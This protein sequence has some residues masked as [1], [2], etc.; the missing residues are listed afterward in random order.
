MRM[1]QEGLKEKRENERQMEI[2]VCRK[3]KEEQ[4]RKDKLEKM[5]K[6]EGERLVFFIFVMIRHQFGVL[7][8]SFFVGIFCS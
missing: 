4:K 2:V 1:I 6:E 7:L 3:R 8:E 5:K